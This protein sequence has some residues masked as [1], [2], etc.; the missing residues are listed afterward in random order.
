MAGQ[1]PKSPNYR[2]PPVEH[3]FKKGQSGNLNG[4]PPKKKRPSV[5]SGGSGGIFD[6]IAEIGSVANFAADGVPV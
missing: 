2:K 6:R 1:V 5:S 3:Q 4:R